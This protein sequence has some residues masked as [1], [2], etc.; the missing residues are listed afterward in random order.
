MRTR[1]TAMRKAFAEEL[2]QQNVEISFDAITNQCGMFSYT[3]LSKPQIDWLLK[4]RGVYLVGSGR[5]CV[6][7]L[8]QNNLKYVAESFAQA[9]KTVKA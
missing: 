3:G 7:A 8:N 4:E 9:I 6:A 1:I 2:K 5:M